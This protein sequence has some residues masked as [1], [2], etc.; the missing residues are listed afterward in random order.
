MQ[1]W[2]AATLIGIFSALI[3]FCIIRVEGALFDLKEGF[4][5]TNWGTSKRFCCT[6][7]GRAPSPDDVCGDWVEWGEVLNP[8]H[9]ETWYLGMA[10]FAPYGIIA[11]SPSA[12][13]LLTPAWTRWT[14]V[15]PYPLP[16]FFSLSHH[17]QGLAPTCSLAKP[18]ESTPPETDGTIPAPRRGLSIAPAGTTKQSRTT[19]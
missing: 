13:K 2:V 11:V 16:I 8:K 18:A 12:Q 5:S 1:G 4:C 14:R 17:H 15:I 3:A 19:A 7:H 10:E 6:P 9:S